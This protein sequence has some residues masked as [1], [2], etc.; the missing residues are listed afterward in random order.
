MSVLA[1]SLG[2][3]VGMLACLVASG[4]FSGAEAA[5]FSLPRSELRRFRASASRLERLVGALLDRPRS[6]LVTILLGNLVINVAYFSLAA[7]LSL[8]LGHAG[9]AGLGVGVSIGAVFLLVLVGEFVPKTLALRR[10]AD[11]SRLVAPALF[12][13]QKVL[14]PLRV[15]LERIARVT[16]R[17]FGGAGPAPALFTDEE[18]D[19]LLERGGE[20]G[21]LAGTEVRMVREVL[22]L[23]EVR[24]REVL[25]P[26]VDLAT[27]DLRRPREELVARLRDRPVSRVVVHRGD[28]DRVEGFLSAR[29]LLFR[30][31][32]S[33]AA[34]VRPL[35][36]VPESKSV[37][38]LLAEMRNEGFAEALVVDEYGGTEGLVTA[39]D[40][41]EEIVGEIADELEDEDTAPL[42]EIE[43][44][45]W[46]VRG[47][48][49]LRDL[50]P[51]LGFDPVAGEVDT[52]G[53]FVAARLGRV[54]AAGDEVR[55]DGWRIRVEAV[56]RRRVR[57]VRLEREGGE[58]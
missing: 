26:R 22:E 1:E 15:V 44:G 19:W 58:A 49:L 23:D 13:L 43:R 3:L 16:S 18:L 39:E 8:R 46:R 20:E 7:D 28:P 32:E 50:V 36:I 47:D 27:F 10:P 54:P 56:H 9:E 51:A 29:D 38:T 6:M 11:F 37:E 30:P 4:F 17:I 34:L 35:R 41:L 57:A 55:D 5:L 45:V 33:L 14:L 24:V 48:V 53:G 25:T 2:A 21:E 12:A 42:A 40:L 31:D 52:V